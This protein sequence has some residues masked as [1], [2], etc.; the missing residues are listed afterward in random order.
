M[1]KGSARL[2]SVARFSKER[3][4]SPQWVYQLLLSKR[5]RATRIGEFP[6]IFKNAK[7]YSKKELL[8]LAK[9]RRLTWQRKG[10]NTKGQCVSYNEKA[11]IV[12]RRIN[13]ALKLNGIFATNKGEF[14]VLGYS[15]DYYEPKLNLVIEWDESHHYK[16]GQLREKDIIRQSVIKK[17]LKCKF[18]RIKQTDNMKFLEIINKIKN[19]KY[20]N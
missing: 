14:S 6:Y 4:I 12:F 7:I 15:V 19:V 2:L 20:L 17:Y 11:C 3:G 5:L 1:E 10:K 13:K 9:K 16:G 8:E 18:I